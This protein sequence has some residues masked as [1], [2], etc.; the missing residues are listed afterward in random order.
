MRRDNGRQ[1]ETRPDKTSG[2][3]TH[4]STQA[5]MW[6]DNG[7]QGGAMGDKGRQDFRKA[8]IASNTTQAHMWGDNGDKWRQG[9][10]MG[11][12]GRQDLWKADTPSNTGTHVGSQ[13]ETMGDKGRQDFGKGDTPSNTGKNTLFRPILDVQMSFRV[14]G[15]R[16]CAPRQKWAKRDGFVAVSKTLAGVGRLKR[17]CEDACRVAGAVQET[18]SS[19]MLRGQ[20]AHFLR[21][22]AFWSMTSSGL[23]RWFFVTGAAL[24]MT[25]PHFFVAGAVV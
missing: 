8:G 16:D 24:R 7:R 25:W 1:G 17:I 6:G 4:H 9:G 3:R 11:D 18:C 10:T 14:A 13:W 22:V 5:H 19:E 23:L 15:A 12:K 20:G 2:R 21:G